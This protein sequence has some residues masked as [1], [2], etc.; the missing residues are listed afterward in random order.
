MVRSR[1][2]SRS[3]SANAA[4]M[5]NTSRP[6]AVVVSICAPWPVRTRKPICRSVKSLTILT[7]WRRSRP[8]RSSFQTTSTSSLRNALRQATRL[9]RLSCL[10]DAGLRRLL[11][12]Q[13]RLRSARPFEGPDSGNRRFS[14]CGHI[15][16]AYVLYVRLRCSPAGRI[17]RVFASYLISQS[18]YCKHLRF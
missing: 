7:R 8:S 4:K 12:R 2:S 1:I 13:R 3:N 5:P 15:R 6:A 18:R 17:R 9:G 16:S 14:R 11:Q 10:P